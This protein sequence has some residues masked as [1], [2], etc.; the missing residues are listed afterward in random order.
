[1]SL[2]IILLLLPLPLTISSACFINYTKLY[3][4]CLCLLLGQHFRNLYEYQTD[5]M[6]YY[7]LLC[8]GSAVVHMIYYV[9]LCTGS[10]VE[11][12]CLVGQYCPEG[13]ISIRQVP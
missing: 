4:D 11:L 5:P 13:V 1:M 9:L 7:V 3:T 12:D 8:T 2:S 10:V 6:I